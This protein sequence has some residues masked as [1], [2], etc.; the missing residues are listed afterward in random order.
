GA[1]TIA[2]EALAPHTR[3]ARAESPAYARGTVMADAA[4]AAALADAL[5]QAARGTIRIAVEHAELDAA[6]AA[7][8]VDELVTIR[9]EPTTLAP[10]LRFVTFS[11]EFTELLA[12]YPT[13]ARAA[14]AQMSVVAAGVVGVAAVV[15][16]L[17]AR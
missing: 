15:I 16:G 17:F 11:A 13:K 5:D 6:T 14:L 8:V 12:G 7:A 10:A 4:T 2:P 1:W 9:S 3:A